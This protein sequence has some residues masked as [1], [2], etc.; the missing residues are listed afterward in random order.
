[1][2]TLK[3][4]IAGWFLDVICDQDIIHKF[5]NFKPFVVSGHTNHPVLCRIETGINLLP[6][7]GTPDLTQ[8]LEGRRLSVW[9]QSDSCF[10]TLFVYSTG[11]SFHLQTDRHWKQVRTDC[12]P[13]TADSYI[14]LGD[15]IMLSFIYSSAFFQTVVIHASCI[16][17]GHSG[18]AFIGPSGI[19]K[20]THSRLWLQHIS[21]SRLLNDDQPVLR[22]MSDGT[23]RLYGSPWSGKTPC[24]NKESVRLDTLFFLRQAQDNRMFPLS[25]IQTFQKL[26]EATSLI[27]QDICSFS[28][29][30]DTL[31]RIAERVPAYVFE[32]LPNED[33]AEQ[34][35]Q[36]FVA[37]RDS[38]S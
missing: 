31:A 10:A 12:L 18:C 34:S 21:G 20:S 32:N 26:L 38:I 36:F 28:E 14:A 9:I 19:G 24:Y 6:E 1:M 8:E 29:I 35:Y 22:L 11:R 4:Q 25:G 13:D 2:K 37:S 16:G 3:L 33:A 17:L 27:G 5:P 23:V 15:F 30:S 7:C